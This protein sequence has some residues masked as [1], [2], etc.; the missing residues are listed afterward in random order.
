MKGIHISLD[1]LIQARL[2]A[3]RL[4]LAVRET[5]RAPRGGAHLSRFRGRGIDFEEVRVYQPGDDIRSM[6]W[7]VTARTGRPHAKVFR[8]ERERPVL[9]AVDLGASMQFGTRVA[10]KA[11]TAAKVAAFW[12]WCAARH[13]DRVGGV[14]QRA[15]GSVEYK[16]RVG[17]PGVLRLLSALAEPAVLSTSAPEQGVA[18]MLQRLRSVAHPGSLI[19]WIS[20]F[21][22]LNATHEAAL[23]ELRRHSELVAVQIY[24]DLE[25]QLPPPG[26]YSVSDGRQTLDFD[27]ANP[28]LRSAY[29]QRF[30]QRTQELQTVLNALSIRLLRI[31]THDDTYAVLSRELR[32]MYGR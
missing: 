24:D 28:A 19:V 15:H 12:A 26:R 7:R 23:N 16:P 32:T 31:A 14:L 29:Q 13:G 18:Q 27:A 30:A 22:G 10:F 6:D 3:Q 20:D 5:A 21:H 4:R 2:L 11:V 8:E 17:H 25:A 1:E 9:F